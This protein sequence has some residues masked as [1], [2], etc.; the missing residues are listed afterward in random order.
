M[1]GQTR[2]DSFNKIFDKEFKKLEESIAKD[3]FVVYP[4]VELTIDDLKK[5]FNMSEND[6][7]NPE[8][9]QL[10]LV[11]NLTPKSITEEIEAEVQE[12]LKN[13]GAIEGAVEGTVEGAVEEE[14]K[15][16]TE[17]E[18]HE[19]FIKTLKESKIKFRN[20]KHD[21]NITTVKFGAEYRKKRQHKN[22]MQK[23]S[24]KANR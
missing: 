5:H 19:L 13:E 18:K 10:P 2:I 21:G 20:V 17:E 22:R 8:S 15:E 24:R 14:E 16:L 4:E 3:K 23:A 1:T 11:E 12:E 6:N 7:V 9:T